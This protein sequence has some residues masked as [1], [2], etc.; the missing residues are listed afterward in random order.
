VKRAAL[1]GAL[2]LAACAGF[3]EVQLHHAEEIA[4]SGGLLPLTL[5]AGGFRVFGFERPGPRQSV[6]VVYIEGDGLA[7]TNPWQASTDPTPTDPIGLQLAAADPA[8]PLLYLARP[9]QFIVSQGCRPALWTDERLSE[10][11]V[12]VF[13]RVIDNARQRTDS[14]RIGLIGYSGGGALATLLAERRDDVAWLITVAANLDL[15]AWVRSR[16]TAPLSGSID[17]AA[18]IHTI[19][20]LPQTH[21]AGSDDA[22]VPPRVVE[23][24][25]ARLPPNAPAR[26]V[27][28]PDFDHF[29]CWPAT[30]NQLLQQSPRS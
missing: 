8:R 27:I 21:F 17:P 28:V 25:M 11:M 5:E 2:L 12:D 13:Q 15:A 1:F 10:A 9:C 14:R 24:F 23:S 7:W 19:E 26:L 4:H 18:Q 20:R 6:L 30:W 22:V 3:R 29:C 16:D